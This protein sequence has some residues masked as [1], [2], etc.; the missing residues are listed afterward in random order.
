MLLYN[1]GTNGNTGNINGTTK[2]VEESAVVLVA[3]VAAG[4]FGS[5][6]NNGTK[7]IVEE[8]AVFMIQKFLFIVPLT[9]YRDGMQ[10]LPDGQLICVNQISKLNL[11]CLGGATQNHVNLMWIASRDG[12]MTQVIT[13]NSDFFSS[14]VQW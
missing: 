9:V 2:V 10:V 7:G 4:N 11:Q 8:S 1:T 3:M 14:A 6:G 13:A 5:N 12:E